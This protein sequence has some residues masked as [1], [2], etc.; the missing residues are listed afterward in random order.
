MGRLNLILMLAVLASGLLLVHS[1]YDARRL[2]SAVDEAR[3]EAR[4]L[5]ADRQRL[6]A[7]RRAQATNLRVET[8][9]HER[10]NMRT[11]TPADTQ[12]VS[13]A[14]PA[15]VAASGASQ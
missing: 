1:A 13:A 14:A 5:D 7:E 8:V 15:S 3:A 2:F 12:V 10:L 4:R 11:I 6:E 9:A